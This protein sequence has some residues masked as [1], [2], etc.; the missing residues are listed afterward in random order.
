MFQPGKQPDDWSQLQSK[1]MLYKLY[2]VSYMLSIEL[3][4]M[5]AK[6]HRTAN[7]QIRQNLLPLQQ[8]HGQPRT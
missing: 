1:H 8:D 4:L 7:L 6:Q 5:G 2:L 3:D